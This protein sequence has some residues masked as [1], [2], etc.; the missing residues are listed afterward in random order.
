MISSRRFDDIGPTTKRFVDAYLR[1]E[2]PRKVMTKQ[3]S[4]LL[5]RLVDAET[6]YSAALGRVSVRSEKATSIRLKKGA[7]LKTSKSAA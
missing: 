6:R 3:G 4:K 2:Y 1:I 5:R 7:G